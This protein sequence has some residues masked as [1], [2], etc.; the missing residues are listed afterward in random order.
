M[1]LLPFRVITEISEKYRVEPELVMAMVSVESSGD[2][3]A[4]RY[5][6]HYSYLYDQE[7]FARRN[8]ISLD[9]EIVLQKSSHGL[10]QVMGGVARESGHTGPMSDLYEPKVGLQYGIAHLVKFIDKYDTLEEALSSYNQ[11][12]PYRDKTGNFKN[13]KYVEK[14]MER[15]SYLKKIR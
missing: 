10:M 4:I 12:G 14:V 3:K 2:T 9:T 1:L 8:N 6:K 11:G 5:E 15:Y 7:S 13:K